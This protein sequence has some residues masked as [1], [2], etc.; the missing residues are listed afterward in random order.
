MSCQLRVRVL[1]ETERR[2][3][4]DAFLSV[5]N[6]DPE[7]RHFRANVRT[8]PERQL[9]LVAALERAVVV[10]S[11]ASSP[12]T[13]DDEADQLLCDVLEVIDRNPALKN[14]GSGYGPHRHLAN[15][16]GRAHV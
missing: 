11:P 15:Q 3:M 13:R 10:G 12:P 6:V 5:L 7:L 4:L 8:G 2:E 14:H 16:I 9:A 1:P